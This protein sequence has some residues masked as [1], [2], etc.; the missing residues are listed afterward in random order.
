MY[1]NYYKLS[2]SAITNY[3]KRIFKIYI[4]L[5][6]IL[7][8][9]ESLFIF[10]Y[11]HIINQMT[12]I[13]ELDY[14]KYFMIFIFAL[15]SLAVLASIIFINIGYFKPKSNIFRCPITKEEKELISNES[16]N[17]SINDYDN[18]FL[19]LQHEKDKDNNDD[20]TIK[21][22]NII[23]SALIDDIRK[24]DKL[25]DCHVKSDFMKQLQNNK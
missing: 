3:Q 22:E 17:Y 15:A 1:L 5:M 12:G 23:K 11:C 7:I 9:S 6:A 4:K 2:E 8:L 25:K 13:T 19:H 18:L 21:R 20:S 10:T 24:L 14:H 16:K